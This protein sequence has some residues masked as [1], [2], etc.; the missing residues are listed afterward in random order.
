[1]TKR[2]SLGALSLLGL[3][4]LSGR[5]LPQ[6]VITTVVGTE[7]L[8]TAGGGPAAQAPLGGVAAVAVDGRGNLYFSAA[9]YG[10]IMRMSPGGTVTV[11]AGN[12][13]R[14][15]S[16]DGGEATSASLFSPWGITLDAAGH[17]Y[18]ADTGNHRVRKV[19]PEGIITTVAGNGVR[20]FLGDGLRA[21]TASLNEPNGVAVDGAGNLYIADTANHRIRKVSPDGAISTV[22]GTGTPGLFGDGG[23]AVRASLQKPYGVA[24][25]RAGVLYIADTQNHAIRKLGPD[26]NL[27]TIAGTG[28]FG[29]SGDGGPA[30]DAALFFP[31][32]V[33]VDAVGNIYIADTQNHR[34]RRIAP[35]GFIS[36]VAGSGA[37]G[38]GG[39]GF[40]G[41]GGPATRALLNAPES[42]AL[43]AAGNL[44]IADFFNRRVRRV[45]PEGTI[46]TF[47][48]NG[49]GF[50]AGDGGPATSASIDGAFGVT[51]DARGS[52]YLADTLNHRI[53][54]V[55][56]DGIIT[57]IA[58]T[59]EAGFS[60]DGGAAA[61]AAMNLPVTV[62]VDPVGSV[63]FAD[64]NNGRVR[65]I[66][67][68]GVITT[69]AGNGG[70]DLGGDGGP[71]TATSLFSPWGLALDAAGNLYIAEAA[72]GRI[73]RVTPAGIISTVAGKLSATGGG[74]D[75]DNKRATD[76][77][78]NSPT[79]VAV[80]AAGALYIS[81]Q[82]NHR[83]RKVSRD[84]IISTIAGNGQRGFSGDGRL[85]TD[86][87]LAFPTGIRLDAAGNLYITDSSNLR[88]RKVTPNG[89]I[90]TVAGGAQ[91]IPLGDG[92]PATNAYLDV[93]RDVAVDLAGNLYIG[94]AGNDRIRA[95]L[96]APPSF[97]ATPASL[98]F[99]ASAGGP[100]PPAREI[101]VIGSVPGLPFSV[102]VSTSR[103]GGWLAASPS[104]G[105]MP[106]IAQISVDPNLAAGDYTG[107][108][109]LTAPSAS[110]PTRTVNVTFTVLV[111]NAPR[112]AVEPDNL[113]FSFTQGSLPQTSTLTVSNR[114]G[115]SLDF[116]AAATSSGG[117]WL[118][119]SAAA[120][121]VTSTT[122][123]LLSVIAD[124]GGLN[125][126]TYL[127]K[128]SVS[129][130]RTGE[131]ITIPV[132][133]TVN[134]IEQTILLSQKG[135]KFTAV[136]GGAAVP[137][138][139]FGVLNTGR[140]VM[141]W[142]ASALGLPGTTSWLSVRPASGSTDAAS[143]RVPL[144]EV[145]ADPRGLVP[146]EYYGT[147]RVS[148]PGAANSP[149]EVAVVLEVLPPGSNPGPAVR[150]A[151]L[152][153][154]GLAGGASPGSQS[155]SVFNLTRTPLTY[156]STA[157]PWLVHLPPDGT[158]TSD[159]P[160]Q[161]V[162]QPDPANLSPGI[163]QGDLTLQFS[164]GSVRSVRVLFVVLRGSTGARQNRLFQAAC[165]PSALLPALTGL[166][167]G[168][169]GRAGWPESLV[170]RMVDNCGARINT[171][172]VVATFS[173]GDPPV[174]MVP[175]GD[176]LWN[177]TW[178]VRNAAPEVTIT[179][180]AE[181]PGTTLKG[182]AQLSGGARAGGNSPVINP[183]G[184]VS[185]AS[186][187]P[188]TPLAPG[189][190][191]SIFGSG[192]ADALGISLRLPL[193]TQLAGAVTSIAG[194][195]LPLLFASDSQINAMIP[196]GLAVNTAHQ[197]VVRRG[198]R[199]AVPELVTVAPAQPAIFTKDRS[200]KGQG[201][202]V[203]LANRYVEPSNP[204]R[205]GDALVIYCTGLGAVEPQVP[206]GA[207]APADPLSRTVNQASLN[208]GGVEAQVFFSGLAPGFAG[209]Y[210]VNALVPP[211]V[212]AGDEVPVVLTVA[213][214][215][216]PPVTIAVR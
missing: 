37:T 182:A 86:A 81:D 75:G 55:T 154:T 51:V 145:A 44:Y 30:V 162:V 35:N 141:N 166:S 199:F 142:S 191:V 116:T 193:E 53:R 10:M 7:F 210:Q 71:A 23:P 181:V 115:G 176:G 50:F 34:I 151:D 22:A 17:L 107:T 188:R 56:P 172:S 139:A 85:A 24:V 192:L 15:F 201:V 207:A 190:L 160:A 25:D 200:G 87:S 120:G 89:I 69:V 14:A 173:N 41:D 66:T 196:Y 40:R 157:P 144:V 38:F 49:I 95:V 138:Q 110:P 203:D 159:R 94:D 104:G 92:G 43:D 122:S 143:P 140:G 8:F 60:G 108:V 171:G 187:T 128:V 134:R 170:V 97:L 18:I 129:S 105:T 206:A 52:L 178:V 198:G 164:D 80:D 62:A 26:G 179:I 2:L 174:P 58:G 118:S 72:A 100:P 125:P 204:A 136:L 123:A 59:G 12:G 84:G 106:V 135:V 197:V 47:A 63:Y 5:A 216:S 168:F 126:G 213:G 119:V 121:T 33:H 186:F 215:S 11:V 202:I 42:A 46:S 177:G 16:G 133:M 137:S 67:P 175:I 194:E 124:P 163:Q 4:L 156:R 13:I 6:N 82:N 185:A 54:Q 161:I 147:V 167:P 77:L 127:G 32:G 195:P 74:F 61:G 9:T 78:L 70:L 29:L 113:A 1:M 64:S 148:A 214:H 189:S 28:V 101:N 180:N 155:V 48:G 31:D 146:G 131:S 212:A 79:G 88:V 208:I 209:L 103:G 165:L 183:G 73:R 184:I 19:S 91:T 98:T 45:T 68:G 27:V 114:G 3:A 57:T 76:A 211:G 90:S 20:G 21:T 169:S 102:T 83:V 130:S 109:T 132:T 117:R 152:V 96:A 205:A 39:G 153:F 93:P 99:S 150:P 149:Q 158:I 65:K 111:A 112:L 36:T